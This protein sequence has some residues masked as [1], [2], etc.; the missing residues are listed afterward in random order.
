MFL[1]DSV[2][3]KWVGGLS[4]KIDDAGRRFLVG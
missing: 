4:T 3:R 2:L 1:V